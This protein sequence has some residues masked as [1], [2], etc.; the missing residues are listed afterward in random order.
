M[1]SSKNWLCAELTLFSKHY[2][3]HG[4]SFAPVVFGGF[5]GNES[6]ASIEG[7]DGDTW[8]Q[9]G[10]PDLPVG[11]HQHCILIVPFYLTMIVGGI[12]EGQ[13]S[14]KTF[15]LNSDS[16]AWVDGPRLNVPR[17]GASCNVLDVAS[18]HEQVIVVAGGYNNDG[19]LSS[20]EVL[21][22]FDS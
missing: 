11:V 3:S 17:S 8:T 7:F 9:Q 5:S 18:I 2:R 22:C 20:T 19:Y 4:A 15:L 10:F 6:L 13:P 14:D 12:Q 21:S 16:S 1:F